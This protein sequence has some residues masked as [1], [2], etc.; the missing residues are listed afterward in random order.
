[1][2]ILKLAALFAVIVF[3]L[4]KHVPVSV[5]LFGAG[6][7]TALMFWVPVTELARGYWSLVTSERFFTL[8]SVVVLITT[9]GS[10]LKE[11]GSLQRLTEACSNL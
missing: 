1:M 6:L 2:E 8:T 9:L 10:L 3:A 5:T 7:L 4:R 11:L